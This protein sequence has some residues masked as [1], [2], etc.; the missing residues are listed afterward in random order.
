MNAHRPARARTGYRIVLYALVGALLTVGAALAVG[1]L[2][3]RELTRARLARLDALRQVPEP[4]TYSEADLE[5]LPPPVQRYFRAVLRDGQPVIARARLTQR[6]EFLLQEAEDGWRPFGARQTFVTRLPGFLWDARIQAAPG[7]VVRVHDAY[8]GGE[9]VLQGALLGLV[10][11][12]DMSGTPEAAEGELMRYLAEGVWIPTA[13]LPNQGVRWEPVDDARAR[14]TLVD[15][16]TSVSL[17][18]TF[19]ADG[20]VSSVYAAARPRDLGG[21]TVPTPW[22][23]RFADYVERD[24]MRIP[25]HG[26]VAWQPEGRHLPYWRGRIVEV[27]YEYAR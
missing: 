24:G 8:I 25:T 21:E 13:L 20:L 9:G 2:R 27:A 16:E 4:A 14:A 15:G 18:F 5:A 17:V 6:G 3:W 12:V 1:T 23:G 10:T 26:E 7:M 11:V 19:G 22:E